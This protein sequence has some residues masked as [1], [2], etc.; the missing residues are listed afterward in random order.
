MFADFS[1]GQPVCDVQIILPPIGNVLRKLLFSC[2]EDFAM[3]NSGRGN[4][5]TCT[6]CH[7]LGFNSI[8]PLFRISSPQCD[9]AM[10]QLPIA[11]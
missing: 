10:Q 6:K 1:M 5:A 9:R 4:E 3:L 8:H 2:S 11:I 7:N